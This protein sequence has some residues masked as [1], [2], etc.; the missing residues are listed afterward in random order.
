MYSMKA[1]RSG[2][3][4]TFLVLT[5]SC[6]SMLPVAC[7]KMEQL[8]KGPATAGQRG[9]TRPLVVFM[10]DFGVA[11][12]AVAICKAVMLGIAP[13]VRIMDIT[14]QVTPYSI[15]EGARLLAEG[16]PL[17]SRWRVFLEVMCPPRGGHAKTV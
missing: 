9:G 17:Q 2:V 12:D 16:A 4:H 1:W 14:H 10:T 15:E 8:A 11:N 5:L 3:I 7:S 13:D 6:V